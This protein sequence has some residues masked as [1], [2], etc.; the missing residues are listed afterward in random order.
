M[1]ILNFLLQI[2]FIVILSFVLPY[3]Y[4]SATKS[5]NKI[6]VVD[7]SVIKDDFLKAIYTTKPPKQFYFDL[8]TNEQIDEEEYMQSLPFTYYYYLINKNKFPPS[9]SYFTSDISLIRQ[10]T[11]NL[12]IKSGENL[13]GDMPLFMLLE[14]EPKYLKL[15]MSDYLIDIEEN[16]KFIDMNTNS[17]DEAL[18]REFISVLTE[19]NVK[20]PI[21]K[22]Y[23]NPSVLKSF[24]EGAFFIDGEDKIYHLKMVNSQPVLKNTQ[25]DL[26][27][28]KKIIVSEH[29]R[30]EFYA[31]IVAQDGV[32]LITYENYKI[33]KIPNF[34]YDFT[35]DNFTLEID[36]LFKTA[37]YENDDNISIIAMNPDYSVY[38][39]HI[40]K[41]E[42]ND[43][44]VNLK[45]YL[46]SFETKLKMESTSSA[47]KFK[48][49]NFSYNSL[50]LS[51]LLC[52]L[53]YFIFRRRG[54]LPLFVVFFGGIYGFLAIILFN[55]SNK[56][57]K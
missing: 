40:L 4:N 43:F 2:C 36:P 47:A 37:T 50:F 24:D 27:N 12:R 52:V 51:A 14:S 17:I 18:S 20:F 44:F 15:E 26:K 19:Q 32:Y 31:A 6:E 55:N 33:I 49:T 22:F 3:I 16:F 30:K 9:L 34:G 42:K 10:N 11:Q 7:F 21:K 1:K 53:A 56:G 39:T 57:K 41:K 8:K 25:I 48:F 28:I 38:K 45:Q 29:S 13:L 5:A 35:K 54:I 46:F 23:S